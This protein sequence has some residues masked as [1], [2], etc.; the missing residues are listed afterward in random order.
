MAR[1]RRASAFARLTAKA[2][3]ARERFDFMFQELRERICLL[4]YPPGEALSEEALAREFGVSRTPIRRVLGR[5]EAAGLVESRH[6]VGTMV[7][8]ID[9]VELEQVYTLRM[10]LAE[11]MGELDPRC[12]TAEELAT[13]RGL[14]DRCEALRDAPSEPEFCR[15]NMA[16]NQLL[17]TLIGNSA[18]RDVTE[19]LYYRSSRFFL[20]ALPGMDFPE[21]IEIFRGEMA[22]ILTALERSDLR[23]VAFHRRNHIAN[24]YYR[25]IRD[26]HDPETEA[27]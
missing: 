18:L 13:L 4:Q 8:V 14:I 2:H 27:D 6:G 21:E 23:A 7:T 10:R 20:Y 1:S 26:R 11:L 22:E 25:I 19:Q 5:L 24:S 17:I 12:A 3:S 15:I 16:F 9:Q